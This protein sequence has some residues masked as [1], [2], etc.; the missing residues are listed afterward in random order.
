MLDYNKIIFA[1]P[2]TSYLY[3]NDKLNND[4]IKLTYALKKRIKSNS[5]SNAGGWQS[6]NVDLSNPV[7]NNFLKLIFPKIEEHVKQYQLKHT[8][9]VIITNLWLNVN[10]PN[11]YNTAHHHI[12]D[13]LDFVGVYYM[14]VPKNSGDL[15]INNPDFSSGSR[16]IFY[17]ERHCNVF[18]QQK[19]KIAAKEQS[20]L[21]FSAGLVHSVSRNNSKSDRLSLSFNIKVQT[22]ND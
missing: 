19:I 21:L 3:K 12:H 6:P 18:N 14:K 22:K 20:L 1:T 5:L 15:F 7:I 17:Q 16:N 4:L 2:L 9:E 8:H 13:A 10:G 11:D